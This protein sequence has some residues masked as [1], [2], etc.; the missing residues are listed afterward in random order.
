ML[1]GQ[2]GGVDASGFS[3]SPTMVRFGPVPAQMITLA[4]G[5][6][7]GERTSEHRRGARGSGGHEFG[8]GR[9]AGVDVVSEGQA[10]VMSA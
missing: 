4:A 10:E 1:G 8:E 2:L 9:V 5:A 3:T 7:K 6:L